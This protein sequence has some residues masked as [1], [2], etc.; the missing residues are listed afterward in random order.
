MP[1]AR[2]PRTW[3]PGG[4]RQACWK[5]F[6]QN[7]NRKDCVVTSAG[8]PSPCPPS[9]QGQGRDGS[10]DMRHRRLPGGF[11]GHPQEH[12]KKGWSPPGASCERW[13]WKGHESHRSPVHCGQTALLSLPLF[14]RAPPHSPAP[15][16]AFKPHPR[17]T[18]RLQPLP[19][20]TTAHLA[21]GL[22]QGL[23]RTQ[24]TVAARDTQALGGWLPPHI[25]H[26]N[27]PW[28]L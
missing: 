8:E 16:P 24:L 1:S 5:E 21:P 25:F 17:C 26:H 28:P 14:C 15:P 13:T 6:I 9:T 12:E 19:A 2:N 4:A 3:Q 22:P 20:P 18:P 7:I 11:S 27:C 10:R 23:L